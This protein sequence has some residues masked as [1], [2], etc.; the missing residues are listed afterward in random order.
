MRKKPNI[1]LFASIV[2]VLVIGYFIIRSSYFVEN[3]SSYI[4]CSAQSTDIGDC[5]IYVISWK[6]VSENAR[7][8][9]DAVKRVHDKTFI[10]NCD[11]N[12][13]MDRGASVI[14]ADDSFYFTKQMYTLFQHCSDHF[15][16]S[17]IMTITGD[18]SPDAD[19]ND[20]IKRCMH[21][22]KK[23]GAGIVAPN[24]DWTAHERHVDIK[25]MGDNYWT[26]ENTDCTVWALK[27]CVYKFLLNTDVHTYSKFG[28]GIDWLLI[29]V[30]EKHN[31]PVIRDY[32]HTIKHPKDHGYENTTAEW[33][34]QEVKNKWNSVYQNIV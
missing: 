2:I 9:F 18:I 5:I 12:F 16:N 8:V 20:I 1:L 27:P 13:K 7:N 21:G 3:F 14:E 25:N 24:V 32:K 34:K 17:P 28:W 4:K 6:R 30:C 10:L 15:P 11:E 33:E 19:W 22:F 26:V 31:M 23:Y 29:Q